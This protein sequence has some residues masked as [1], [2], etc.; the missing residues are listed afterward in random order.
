MTVNEGFKA[1]RFDVSIVAGAQAGG[2][3]CKNRVLNTRFYFLFSFLMAAIWA[4]AAASS[5]LALATS[6]SDC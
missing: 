6:R 3:E 2:K 4:A 1:R 5:A